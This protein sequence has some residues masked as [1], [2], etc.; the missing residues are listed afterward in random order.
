MAESTTVRP[1][2]E[3]EWHF[4]DWVAYR[5]RHDRPALEQPI[6]TLT[7]RELLYELRTGTSR[8]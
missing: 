5:H 6:P 7:T 1:A 3:T 2:W 4:A 8:H